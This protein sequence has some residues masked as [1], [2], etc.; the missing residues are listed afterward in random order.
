MP[1]P[2]E[3]ATLTLSQW[4]SPAFPLGAFAYSHGLESA[5]NAGWITKASQLETWLSD[6]LLYGTGR[7]DSLFI[8]AAYLTKTERQLAEINQTVRAFATTAERR[9]ETEAQGK[10]FGE[11]IR[12]WD[13]EL[14]ILTLPVAL[15]AAAAKQRF[16]LKLTQS[17]FL[18][19]FLT[20]LILVSQRI[21]P[22]GQQEG[23][24]ILRRLTPLT[25]EIAYDTQSGDLKA[26]GSTAF[27]SEISAMQHEQQTTRIFR[28]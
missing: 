3:V 24:R 5:C 9:L 18:S 16:P 13:I 7:S 14:G 19:A 20:N 17:L 11:A 23:L 15:G 1:T 12:A 6:I 4:L 10:A 21:L 27:L 26:L 2:I 8:A 25:H 28:S 22:I